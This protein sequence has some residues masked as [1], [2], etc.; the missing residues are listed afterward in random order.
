MIHF[1]TEHFLVLHNFM[2]FFSDI[3]VNEIVKSF[4][5]IFA[6]VKN[7]VHKVLLEREMDDGGNR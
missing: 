4:Q 7:D 3:R 6:S 5:F 1:Y 2:K